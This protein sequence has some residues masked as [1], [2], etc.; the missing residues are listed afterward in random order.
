[1]GDRFWLAAGIA[2]ALAIPGGCGSVRAGEVERACDPAPAGH[3]RKFE[4]VREKMGGPFR[5]VLH[6]PDEAS[7]NRAADAVYG[8]VDELDSI[9]SDYDPDSE[10]SRL[11]Q[12]TLQG[13][14]PEPVTVSEDLFRV[15][16]RGQQI[17]EQTDG[18]F[19]VTVGPYM[20]L[21][22]RARELKQLPTE[23]RLEKTRPSVGWRHVRLDP[24]ARTVQLLAPRM[25]LDVGGLALGY[26]ADQAVAA[27]AK[28]GAPSALVDAGGEISVGEAP[29]GKD[30][31]TVAIQSLKDPE[32]MTGEQVKIVRACVSSS[33]DTRRFV[34]LAG[35]RYS[36]I[37]DPRTG[38]G[39][40][41][42]IGATV[43]APDGMTADALDTAVCVL[44]PEKGLE[45]IER[46]AGAAAR[47]TTIE[48]DEVKVYE[49][50]RFKEFVVKPE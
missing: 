45:L 18:A 28:A 16:A 36:H 37:I 23:E 34:E 27:A 39:L 11:S 14:M 30:G 1:M 47:I 8:R 43:I 21:W 19:D 5:L 24:K 50:K 41:R 9:L 42:R 40:T 6:A 4:F 10:I 31:W 3:V 2:M 44:G 7:A 32:Q 15:L 20:R 33:G 26:I 29:P 22:R 49:S 13:P 12:R 46:T 25:R 48:G 38:L 35:K 17:A